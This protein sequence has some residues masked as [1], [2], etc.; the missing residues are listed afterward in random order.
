MPPQSTWTNEELRYLEFSSP[1]LKPKELSEELNRP[2]ETIKNQMR[3]MG[4]DWKRVK[5]LEG[6]K[7]D[8][9]KELWLTQTPHE[10]AAT[11][12]IPKGSVYS[13]AKRLKLTIINKGRTSEMARK[14]QKASTKVQRAN[15]VNYA[16]SK[17]GIWTRESAYIFGV[18]W[19]DGFSSDNAIGLTVAA[20]DAEWHEMLGNWIKPGIHIGHKIVNLNGKQYPAVSWYWSSVGAVDLFQ[21]LGTPLL[22]L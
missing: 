5:G 19:A 10:I 18:L 7:D 16:Q 9:I 8:R 3:K 20:K 14:A 12:G 21:A 17:F 4:L 13:A 15:S 11:L 2:I 1:N 6:T 22:G